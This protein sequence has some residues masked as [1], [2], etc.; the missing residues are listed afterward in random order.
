MM[1][2]IPP[3]DYPPKADQFE[4]RSNQPSGPKSGGGMTRREVLKLTG[5]TGVGLILASR[6]LSLWALEPVEEIENP[7]A[8]YPN[9]EWEKVY[10]DQYRYDSKFSWVCS[11]NDTHACRVTAFVRNGIAVRMGNTYDYQNYADIY[12]NKATAN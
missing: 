10:R 4:P 7:L 8:Y 11:P 1:R 2:M 12:G 9:R 3:P 6:D 5:L